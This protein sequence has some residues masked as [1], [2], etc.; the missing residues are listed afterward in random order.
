MIY[1]SKISRLYQYTPLRVKIYDCEY[2]ALREVQSTYM[3]IMKGRC[4]KIRPSYR[5]VI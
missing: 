1:D 2:Q 3:F 5:L 4:K